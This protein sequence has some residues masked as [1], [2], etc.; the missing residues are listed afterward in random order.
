VPYNPNS[1]LS[2]WGGTYS[3]DPNDVSAGRFLNGLPAVA[4]NQL[5]MG[6][7]ATAPPA[8]S[9]AAPTQ[10]PAAPLPP[11][12]QGRGLAGAPLPP[13]NPFRVPNNTPPIAAGSG[14]GSLWDA[15]RGMF[16]PQTGP[17]QGMS[18][19]IN[20]RGQAGASTNTLGNP[21]GR[22]G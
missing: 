2:N 17:P 12:L 20:P 8:M 10:Q 5:S 21:L 13:P 3:N 18:G 22:F 15:L 4:P 14:G 19:L 1:I 6:F 7:P 16:S 11:H 9:M